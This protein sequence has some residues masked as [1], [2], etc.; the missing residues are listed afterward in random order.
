[1]AAPATPSRQILFVLALL[2]VVKLGS[3]RPQ[4]AIDNQDLPEINPNELRKLYTNY[5]SY[6]SNQ[7]DNYGLDPLQ[8]QLLAQ[9]A[10]SNAISGGGGGWDQL[11][12]APE[13]KRQIRYR[14]CYFNPISCFKK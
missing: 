2:F 6:V 10:Q 13:M 8:L 5:N 4:N 7:L 14:Q 9:Y 3:G 1:M 12:R 11:Y